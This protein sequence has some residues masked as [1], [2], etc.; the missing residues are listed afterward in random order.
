[1]MSNGKRILMT[2][3]AVTVHLAIGSVYAYSVMTL[4]LNHLLG[5]QKSDVVTAFSTAIFFLGISAAFLGSLTERVS[6]KKLL[7]AAAAFYAS[8]IFISGLAIQFKLYPLFVL[9]YGAIAG[10]GL[11][12]GYITPVTVLVKWFPENKGLAT[13]LVIMGFGFS[14]MIVGPALAKL[15]PVIGAA[16][17]LIGL[18]LVYGTMIA[19]A[20]CVLENPPANASAKNDT[21][22]DTFKTRTAIA[23]KEFICLW[24]M[25]FIN[26][27]CGIALISAASPMAQE[28]AKMTAMAAAMMVGVMGVFN[29][30]G[31]FVWSALSDKFG[32]LN[33]Y[34]AFYVIQIPALIALAHTTNALAFQSLLFLIITCYGGGFS[35]APAFLGDTF[36]TKNLGKIYGVLLTA[37]ALAGVIGP[38]LA[39]AIREN[40]GS[41]QGSLSVFAG[42]LA[43]A[44][45][46]GLFLRFTAKQRA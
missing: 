37:W 40:T 18:S 44:F 46:I 43:I 4:P 9:G 42:L 29:G 2:I 26:I 8:G 12:L 25:F 14:S 21:T 39:A 34:L 1:M 36:G 19:I 16:K 15:F 17:T 11:G 6:P 35:V 7:A 38:K 32:R 20:A 10:I 30:L 22:T 31:R 27:C 5:W 24:L 13:G 45:A 33:I 3:A 28:N 23:S 41:Y